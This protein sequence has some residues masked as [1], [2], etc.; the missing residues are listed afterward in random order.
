MAESNSPQAPTFLQKVVADIFDI[1]ETATRDLYARALLD[2]LGGYV[3]HEP[4]NG[5]TVPKNP[6]DILSPFAI[7]ARHRIPIKD[8]AEY[9]ISLRKTSAVQFLKEQGRRKINPKTELEGSRY[10]KAFGKR[11]LAKAGTALVFT[12]AEILYLTN[13][14]RLIA[15]PSDLR[16]Y[17]NGR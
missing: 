8:Q 13:H 2:S 9:S 11:K 4:E 15:I 10:N 7:E 5:Q 6:D 1:P 14:L 12:Y 17:L 16:G 3:V